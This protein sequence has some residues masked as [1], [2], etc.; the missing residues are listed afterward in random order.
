MLG[1]ATLRT[2]QRLVGKTEVPNITHTDDW[3]SR[4]AALQE[5]E[6]AKVSCS[7][8]DCSNT[9]SRHRVQDAMTLKTCKATEV[10]KKVVVANAGSTAMPQCSTDGMTQHRHE[11]AQFM[12]WNLV[13][14]PALAQPCW[15]LSS[16]FHSMTRRW[17]CDPSGQAEKVSDKE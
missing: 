13:L 17:L 10:M 14:D 9:N 12:C 7:D 8:D 16:L 2:R 5:T 3:D 4:N 11:F 6:E 15:N 1:H